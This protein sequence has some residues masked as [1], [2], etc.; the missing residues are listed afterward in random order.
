MDLVA[1][2]WKK[3]KRDGFVPA[4]SSVFIFTRNRSNNAIRWLEDQYYSF[5]A[6]NKSPIDYYDVRLATD[7]SV[8]TPKVR[9][10]FMRGTYELAEKKAV[11]KYYN[12]DHNLIDLGASSGFLT[13]LADQ[14]AEQ[15]STVVAVEANPDLIPFIETT[16]RLNDAGFELFSC[17]YHS[18]RNETEFNKHNLTVG[19][20]I[21]RGTDNK[22]SVP[23]RSLTDIFSHFELKYSVIVC[24]IEGGETDLLLNEIDTLEERCPLLVIET[25]QFAPKLDNAMEKVKQ[26][27]LNLEE[28]IGST[29]VYSNQ[30]F[31]QS[32]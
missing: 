32:E 1:K 17:A 26:S 25:H 6:K 23:A 21:Q 4:V 22:L 14:R 11:E 19:G 30:K 3:I 16:K 18:S 8:F 15:R 7:S 31:T 24:D 29:R 10:R 9:A 5:Q 27:T 13:T 28:K 2:F 12:G 20:S